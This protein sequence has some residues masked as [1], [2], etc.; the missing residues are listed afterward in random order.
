MAR[1]ESFFDDLA[2][3]LADG[4]VTRSRALRLMGAAVVGGTLGSLGIG[5]EASADPPGCKR[6]GKH[7][8]RNEQC[9]SLNCSGGSCRAQT[10]TTTTTPTTTTSTSTTSTTTPMCLPNNTAC[11]GDEDCC[12]RICD[13]RSFPDF[14]SGCRFPGGS[15]AAGETCC[16]VGSVNPSTCVNGKCCAPEQRPCNANTPCCPGLMCIDLGFGP[17]C[18]S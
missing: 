4:S 3:G 8:T 9:C 11:S 12:S 2:R 15:C 7:C 16:D 5:A 14:C 6:N 1:G 13:S 17:I 18:L 10:T